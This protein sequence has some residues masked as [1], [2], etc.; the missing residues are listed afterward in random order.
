MN[1]FKINQKYEIK[2]IILFL[3]LYSILSCIVN[4]I[5]NKQSEVVENIKIVK[6]VNDINIDEWELFKLAIIKEMSN[7]VLDSINTNRKTIGIFQLSETY[8]NDYTK[9]TQEI[10]TDFMMQDVHMH[11]EIFNR[12]QWIYNPQQDFTR[13]LH[14]LSKYPFKSKEL[15]NLEKRVMYWYYKWKIEIYENTFNI[16]NIYE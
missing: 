12:I 16:N 6:T 11:H 14:L 8:I 1:Q 3:I 13:A 15:F 4:C 5:F 2:F 10:V 9:I 7:N